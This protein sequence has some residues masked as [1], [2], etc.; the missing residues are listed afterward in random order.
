MGP[1]SN[2]PNFEKLSREIAHPPLPF[3]PADK[4]ALDRYLGRAERTGVL[5]QKR[6]RE[7]LAT[8]GSHTPLHEHLLS[9]FPT[10]DA[11]RLITTNFDRHFSTAARTVFGS[12][13]IREY[14][15]PALP[16]GKDFRG[17]AQLHGSLGNEQDRLV[18]T[19]GDF[20]AAYMVDGWAA[21]FLVGVFA[22]R[23]VLFVG[24]SLTDPVMRYLLH[25][26]PPTNRW[27]GLAHVD[28]QSHWA[29]HDISVV[30]F[31]TREDGERYGELNDGLQRWAWF[32]R[33]S[34]SDHD[35]KLRSMIPHGPPASPE[36]A[37]YLR[38]RL[39]T[40]VGRAAFFMEA[41]DPRWLTWA[42]GEGLLDGLFQDMLSDTDG[43]EVS[44]WLYWCLTRFS[45]GEN[46]PLLTLVRNRSV[47]VSQAFAETLAAHLFRTDPLPPEPVLRQFVALLVSRPAS[48]GRRHSPVVP[49]AGKLIAEGRRVET[50]ALLRWL[51]GVMLQTR[52]LHFMPSEDDPPSELPTLSPLV[53]LAGSAEDLLWM[54]R[55]NGE[56]LAQMAAGEIV[57]LGEQRIAEAYALLDLAR[58]P[59][60]SIDWLSFGRTSI[61][62]SNQDL[63]A[64]AED[65]LVVLVRCG[66]AY[67]GVHAPKELL[68]FGERVSMDE[69]RLLRRLG[70][71]ALAESKSMAPDAALAIAG[72]A[73]WAGDIW[74][75][76]ELFLL[77]K[78][79][80]HGASEEAKAAYVAT[81]GHDATW[82][83]MGEHQAENRFGIAN[84]LSSLSPESEVTQ[85]FVDAERAAY[86]EWSPK[87][88]DPDG[89]L[90]R[91]EVFTGGDVPSPLESEQMTSLAPAEAYSRIA[92]FLESHGDPDTRH[93]LLGAAQQAARTD[94]TW[95][96]QMITARASGM[97]GPV[98]VARWILFG[99]RDATVSSADQRAL[100]QTL[101][102]WRWD[103][104]LTGPIGLV[105][106]QWARSIKGEEADPEVLDAFDQ[107]ADA[108]YVR[109]G[110]ELP[111]VQ[112][113]S[114][115]YEHA[116]HHSGGIAAR[117]WWATAHARNRSGGQYVLSISE[118]ER[119]RWRRVLAEL[120]P[121]GIYARAI[122][123]FACDRYSAGDFAWAERELFPKF[124]PALDELICGPLWDGRLT[125]PHWSWVTLE[126]LRPYLRE[127]LIRSATLVPTRSVHLGAAIALFV[128][129]SDESH[130]TYED[131]QA[132]IQ[133]ALPEA[134]HTFA[135]QLPQHLAELSPEARRAVWGTTLLPYWR[136]RRTN[137]PVALDA[138]EIGAMLDWIFALPEVTSEVMAEIGKMEPSAVDGADRLFW[139]WREDNAWVRT[140]PAEATALI[141][142][143]AECKS[144]ESWSAT[145]AV[146]HL[147]TALAAGADQADVLRAA[148]AIAALP[149]Q[150]AMTLISRLRGPA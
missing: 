102:G 7:K 94:A 110:R 65:V 124:D 21:R 52:D 86:P 68:R 31:G 87:R 56:K 22:S 121:N 53:S 89:Y 119:D 16:P 116:S 72:R 107:A 147:E 103:D 146:T 43:Q 69:R 37:D 113:P 127:F 30:T 109:G 149:S 128:S 33:A 139:E 57:A 75:R 29:D 49:L 24:Y 84:L 123:G 126:G 42:A 40:D 44:G 142:W 15:G 3:H 35:R 78:A 95:G 11:V 32:A 82:A 2:L 99:L 28:E 38:A 36:D 100:L 8:G 131:L 148:E 45:V 73:R 61:A 58:G 150:A 85:A 34:I 59:D 26:I 5:V 97:I 47:R 91:V 60:D 81:L 144:I 115:W 10:P 143:L 4:E 108:L 50:L 98:A 93:A 54:L 48:D 133:H 125:Q 114:G 6:A 88:Y 79:H 41:G 25:A 106:E 111:T 104:E 141:R 117:V 55:G 145:D 140:Y 12:T 27:Y 105:L 1:P 129:H 132:F 62:P 134:R 46:P 83:E 14:V 136:D 138:E 63:G 20:A 122:L 39:R 23:T 51:T 92:V 64:H 19:D 70:I 130:F 66:L 137:V 118:A 76:P 67:W 9:L 96:V 18:L 13:A 101:A 135:R 74:V 112:G 71:Y 120:L 77:L 17:I 90:S 80:Y